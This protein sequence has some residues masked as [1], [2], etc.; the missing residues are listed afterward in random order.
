MNKECGIVRDLMPLVIDDVAG[1][2]SK[3]FVE[4]HLSGCEECRTICQ[5]L[6]T[7]V[8]RKPE[9]EKSAEQSAFSVAAGKLKKKGRIRTLKHILLGFLIASI[10][11]VAGLLGYS[12]LTQ[13][14]EHIYFGF[15]RVYLS[16]LTNGNVVFT[17]DYNGSDDDLSLMME[18][19]YEMNPK[20]GGQ[21]K[22]LYVWLEKYKLPRKQE[23]PRQN[24]PFMELTADDM[25]EYSEIRQGVPAE[26]QSLWIQGQTISK[27]SEQ[28]E[29]YYFWNEIDA[30]LWKYGKESYDGKVSISDYRLSGVWSMIQQQMFAVA[31]TVPEW[32]PWTGAWGIKE[33]PLDQETISHMLS[34]LKEAGIKLPTPNPYEAQ[35]NEE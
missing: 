18:D 2:E 35:S 27:A 7:D 22:I 12:K 31:S 34:D 8:P 11:L 28:M 33:E 29:E 16:E 25:A 10:V 19:A 32:Q 13:A 1:D 30:K 23:H 21:K 5:E 17:M 6:N 24:S 4:S 3:E 9:E 26:Y 20:T 14:K 15:Y